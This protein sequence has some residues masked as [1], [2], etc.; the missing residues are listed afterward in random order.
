[1]STVRLG[2]VGLGNIGRHHASYLRAGRIRGA[3]LVAVADQSEANLAP[4]DS[5]KKFNHGLDLIASGAV[6]AVIIATPHVEHVALGI[7]A[8]EKGLHVLVEKPIAAHLAD[9]Q[10]LVAAQRPG[11]VF[12][13]MFQMRVE[14]RY[15][16][17]RDLVRQGKLGNLVRLSWI[18]TDWFRP[19]AYYASSDWRATWKGEG[20]GVLLNQA[21]HNLDMLQWLVG[22]PARVRGF[23]KLG[24]FH[25]IEVEDEVSAYLEF[26]NGAT[27]TFVTSTGEA[28]GTNR[29]EIAGSLGKI[30]LEHDR[31]TWMRNDADMFEFSRTTLQPF[32][33]P[34]S[35]AS[36]VPFTN[37]ENGH[38][39]IMQNFVDAIATG[40]PLIAPGPEGIRSVELAN[41]V[42]YSSLGDR[43]IELPLDAG[44]Y[45]DTL[46]RLI[47]NSTIVKRTIPTDPADMNASFKR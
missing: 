32:S 28:P 31:L 27:G 42:L 22:M 37:A 29:L 6:D 13:G 19:E 12:A 26:P 39:V 34:A 36:V 8:F 16:A 35:E 10:R 45:E 2:L 46:R 25:H 33:K 40:E 30:V 41:A 7:A 14:P 23:C 18:N 38:A 21:L 17:I 9:A 47:V 11:L 20:G 44:A 24:R 5:L 3:A 43:T 1:M 15:R 4:F